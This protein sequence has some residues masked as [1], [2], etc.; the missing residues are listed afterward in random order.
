MSDSLRH[1]TLIKV[2]TSLYMASKKDQSVPCVLTMLPHTLL[3]KTQ[4]EMLLVD[5]A[6]TVKHCLQ[7]DNGLMPIVS[8]HY[9]ST[10]AS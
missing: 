5:S 10:D 9:E 3:G 8:H 6:E 2:V 1:S 7:C 4:K